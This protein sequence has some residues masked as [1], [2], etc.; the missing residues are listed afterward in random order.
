MPPY[1][2]K[3]DSFFQKAILRAA[4]SGTT[5]YIYGYV[6]EEEIIEKRTHD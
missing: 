3:G 1:R 4:P 2:A 5:L 6:S